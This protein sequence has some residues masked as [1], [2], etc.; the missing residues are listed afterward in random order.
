MAVPLAPTNVRQVF[1][2]Q[3]TI[4][5]A[6]DA[7]SSGDA[8]TGYAY[9][10]NGQG[11]TYAFNVLSRELIGLDP[12]TAYTFEVRGGNASGWGAWSAPITIRT[13]A[14]PAPSGPAPQCYS[15]VRGSAIR[16]TGLDERGGY[17]SPVR[18]A[19]SKSVASVRITEVT[20]AGQNEVFETP[21][22][23]KRLRLVKPVQTIRNKVDVE[24]LRVDPGVLSLVAGVRLV[25][26][27]TPGFGEV[28]FGYAPFGVSQGSVRG[29]DANTRIKP[30]GFALEV[31]SKLD[32]NSAKAAAVAT[33]LG[34]DEVP[35]D[36]T[37]FDTPVAGMTAPDCTAR[38]WGY[39]VFPHLRGGRLSG[40]RFENGLVSFNLVGAQTRKATRWGVGPHDI[41]GEHQRLTSPVSRNT[42]FRQMITTG[43]PP[44]QADGIQELGPDVLDNGTAANPMPDPD[45]VL[46]IDGGGA[47]TSAW[48]IDGGRAS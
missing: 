17:G 20:E 32:Q 40:F 43:A 1:A 27:D 22:E 44:A 21:D 29:F 23:E 36:V 47:T 37:P 42:M 48:I 2:T 4:V 9:R 11:E 26:G 13:T 46:A 35:F 14:V 18:Y 6:W 7:P 12:D 10:L 45:A 38:R 3:S 31:W 5:V 41:E 30:V 25:Y 33:M 8:P 24:F 16:V 34:F 39:T 28:P 15:M 19:V